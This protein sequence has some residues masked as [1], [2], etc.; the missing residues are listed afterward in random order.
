[1]A[2]RALVDAICARSDP[3]VSNL[4]NVIGIGSDLEDARRGGVI[5][6]E[7]SDVSNSLIGGSDHKVNVRSTSN[8]E[9]RVDCS[10]LHVA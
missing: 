3:G 8:V 7:L 4:G 1:L 10:H 9:S 5:E 6:E 2:V